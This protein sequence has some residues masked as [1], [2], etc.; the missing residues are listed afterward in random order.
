M[1]NPPGPGRQ[2][3]ASWLWCRGGA[4]G[5][6]AATL[7]PTAQRRVALIVPPILVGLLA[8]PFVL[9][10]NAW[11]EW[12]TAFWLLER[13][14]AHVSE[15]GIPTLFLQTDVGRFNDFYVFYGGF[16]FSVLAY[17][18]AILGAWPVF[19]ATSVLAAVAGYLG[20]AW[21]ARNL[22]LSARAAI[23]PGLIF[24]TTPYVVSDLYGRGAW[25]EFLAVN[26]AAVVLGA[27]TGLVLRPEQGRV[28]CG[29]AL[30]AAAAVLAGA[31]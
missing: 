13:Q 25:S 27:F 6:V 26:A 17:P 29:A 11:W 30:A 31:H 21:T 23:L 22:G 20:I 9:R 10:Q 4:A 5:R 8:L 18:A 28:R 15:H 12:T 7:S 3:A 2:A 16:T 24:S 14:A 19:A 1:K